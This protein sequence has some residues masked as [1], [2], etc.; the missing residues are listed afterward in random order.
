MKLR[1]YITKTAPIDILTMM[2]NSMRGGATGVNVCIFNAFH[3]TADERKV[4]CEKHCGNCGQCI[5]SM[6]DEEVKL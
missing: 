4:R 5:A 2:N 1:E 6:L 3:H